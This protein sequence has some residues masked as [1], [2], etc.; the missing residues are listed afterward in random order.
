MWTLTSSECE[1]LLWYDVEILRWC[2]CHGERRFRLLDIWQDVDWEAL[3]LK[4][5][6]RGI[7]G[8][9]HRPVR[10][11]PRWLIRFNSLSAG[12]FSVHPSSALRRTWRGFLRLILP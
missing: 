5:V 11:P 9:P 12:S 2:E 4:A 3:R 6:A 7:E 8:V 10:I 1:D